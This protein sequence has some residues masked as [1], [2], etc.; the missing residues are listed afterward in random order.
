VSAL[1]V[2]IVDDHPGFRDAARELLSARG[3]TVVAE[4]D[5]GSSALQALA[6]SAPDAVLLDM[7]LG[8]ESGFDV[9]RTLTRAQPDLAVLLV[10]AQDAGAYAERALECG[11]RGF[12]LKRDLVKTNLA[13]LWGE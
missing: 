13:R 4:A 10:S 9:A 12:V 7:L 1:R 2:L 5:S 8:R 3:Y 6:R 11:A